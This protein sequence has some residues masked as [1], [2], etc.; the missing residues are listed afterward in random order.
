MSTLHQSTVRPKEVRRRRKQRVIDLV[1][2]GLTDMRIA[3]LTGEHLTQVRLWRTSANLEHNS[4]SNQVGDEGEALVLSRLRALGVPAR[5]M[6]AG[7]PFDID[8]AGVRIEVKTASRVHKDRSIGVRFLGFNTCKTRS[9]LYGHRYQ[10][11]YQDDCDFLIAVW[12]KEPPDFWV[13]P[14]GLIPAGLKIVPRPSRPGK[15]LALKNRFD[16]IAAARDG[17]TQ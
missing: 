7:A 1:H 17:V 15:Y 8:A 5:R 4:P 6:P 2:R 16:L 11:S 10:K 3:D 13:I 14:S 12:L 9:S